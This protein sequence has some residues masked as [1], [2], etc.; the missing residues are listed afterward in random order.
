M[1][2]AVGPDTTVVPVLNGLRHLDLLNAAFG[3]ARVLGGVALLATQLDGN[4]D[5]AVL[6][7]EAGLTIG[8]QDGQRTPAVERTGQLLDGA[9]FQVAI[10]DD[11]LA[12]MWSKWDRRS[13]RRCTATCGRAG[14]S[15]WTRFSATCSSTADGAVC[16]RRCWRP[17]PW[18]CAF[19]TTGRR[20]AGQRP[21][22]GGPARA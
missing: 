2:P 11:I 7:P 14:Q 16:A 18:S 22:A 1:A 5:V 19:T 3:S 4:G 17:P 12:A 10:S 15:K 8:A 9:G 20:P 21:A 13:P 6:S